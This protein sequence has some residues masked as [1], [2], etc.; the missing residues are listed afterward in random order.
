MEEL[1]AVTFHENGELLT[2][3]ISFPV[4]GEW[5]ASHLYYAQSEKTESGEEI[6]NRLPV[7][8]SIVVS[9]EV[10][11]PKYRLVIKKEP[12]PIF[13]FSYNKKKKVEFYGCS[14]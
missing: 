9:G 1:E 6:A 10:A 5:I 4:E 12:Y 7:E 3:D 13:F 8:F 14:E 2:M 11:S